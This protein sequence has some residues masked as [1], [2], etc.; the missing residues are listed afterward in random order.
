MTATE[1]VLQRRDGATLI[2]GVVVATAFI[3]FL[4]SITL[5]LTAK[6][7]S[8]S[9]GGFTNTSFKDQYLA[10]LVALVIELLAIELFIWLVIGVRALAYSKTSKKRK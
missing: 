3:Q 4:M 1:K 8:Q 10:P 6:V 7:M 5:P 9:M 2:T